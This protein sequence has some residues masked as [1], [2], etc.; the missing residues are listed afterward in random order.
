MVQ[1]S[2]ES[3]EDKAVGGEAEGTRA[4]WKWYELM[5]SEASIGASRPMQDHAGISKKRAE[6]AHA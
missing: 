3:E 5:M 4:R 1:L 2:R 6:V